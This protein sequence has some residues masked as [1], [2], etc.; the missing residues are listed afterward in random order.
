M[1]KLYSLGNVNQQAPST[2]K[3]S[4]IA[5]LVGNVERNINRSGVKALS[6]VAGIPGD[7]GSVALQASEYG[8]NKLTGKELGAGK[9]AE[10]LPTSDKI[11][12]F[13]QKGVSKKHNLASDYWDPANRAE[14]TLDSV[15]ETLTGLLTVGGSGIKTA[16]KL[17]GAKE[18]G[19]VAAEAFGYGELGQEVGGLGAML[20]TSVVGAPRVAQQAKNV[21]E[22][23]E[24]ATKKEMPYKSNIIKNG[25]AKT[26]ENIV[27]LPSSSKDIKDVNEVLG[28][29][30]NAIHPIKDTVDL[31]ALLKQKKFINKSVS[32][33]AR[34]YLTPLRNSIRETIKAAEDTYPEF[35][36]EYL[37]ADKL[38]AAARTAEEA[39]GFI[40]KHV[41][42]N[43][44]KNPLIGGLFTVGAAKLI[45]PFVPSY[46]S[47][48]IGA[49][50]SANSVKAIIEAASVLK[51]SPEARKYYKD[52]IQ[53]ALKE[54]STQVIRSLNKLDGVIKKESKRSNKG[55]LY[56]LKQ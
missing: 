14:K 4:P 15:A 9:V 20:L 40:R 18:L 29:V 31:N 34:D 6:S 46:V 8:Y 5:D 35:S 36:K 54:S 28:A 22:K 30:E 53:G 21:Y 56:P 37:L 7:I 25:I 42:L 45:E 41:D 50:G 49:L 39:G 17:A 2:S 1:T 23:A 12:K 47:F 38:H 51:D 55:G 10:Y 48:G 16:A 52:I 32:K 26:T 27:D 24:K 43:K 11:E 44:T 3:S 13:I 19:K 33:E